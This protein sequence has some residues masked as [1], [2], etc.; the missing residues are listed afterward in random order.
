MRLSGGRM[1]H[2]RAREA[3]RRGTV[4]TMTSD[5]ALHDAV[6]AANDAFYDAF[7]SLDISRME[8]VWSKGDVVTCTHPG[9]ALLSGWFE[10]MQSWERIFAGAATMTFRI[11]EAEA[12][13]EGEVAWVTCAENL[14]SVVDGRVMEARVEATNIFVLRDG[15]WLLTHHHGSPVAR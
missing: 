4:P 1:I 5:N 6:L 3:T 7:S 11:A 10:V 15:H 8:A 13:V 9:W 12:N 14:V 2:R